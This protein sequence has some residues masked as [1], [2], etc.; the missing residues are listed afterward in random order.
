[1]SRISFRIT[2]CSEA[3]ARLAITL[4]ITGIRDAVRAI[5]RHLTQVLFPVVGIPILQAARIESTE[6]I[7]GEEQRSAKRRPQGQL[8]AIKGLA[9][10]KLWARRKAVVI[11]HWIDG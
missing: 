4:E 8:N 9:I 10:E 5:D 6:R 1:M 3:P 7:M 2:A 11:D